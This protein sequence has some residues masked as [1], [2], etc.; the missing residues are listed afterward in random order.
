MRGFTMKLINNVNFFLFFISLGFSLELGEDEILS[1]QTNK[2]E[3]QS[4]QGKITNRNPK[5]IIIDIGKRI[6]REMK[7]NKKSGGKKIAIMSS[8]FCRRII[9]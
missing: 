9:N 3:F 2:I 7:K 6:T 1:A 5:K 4:W 8:G